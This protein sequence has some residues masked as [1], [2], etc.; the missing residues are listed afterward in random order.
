[1]WAVVVGAGSGTRFGSFKQFENVRGASLFSWSIRALRDHVDGVVAVVPPV[2]PAPSDVAEFVDV[3]VSGGASR[4]AS[5][6][7]GLAAIPG[8][9]DW[10]LIHDA[11]R[12]CCA[13]EVVERVIDALAN[14]RHAV[15]PTVAVIDTI[16]TM[17]PSGTL[18]TLDRNALRAAQTPQGFVVAE[19]KRAHAAAQAGGGEATDDGA[20]MEDVGVEVWSVAGDVD[21]IKVT[22]RDDLDKVGVWLDRR[23]LSTSEETS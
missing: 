13:P 20:V 17:S 4:S 11:A 3:V 12:P 15:V 21:N 23:A 18:A 14:G 19:L 8:S 10:V 2:A 7:A 16:K 5:V 1:M 6:R 22:T 9:A